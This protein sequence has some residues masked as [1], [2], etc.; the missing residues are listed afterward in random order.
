[1]DDLNERVY[2]LSARNP[3]RDDRIVLPHPSDITA[4]LLERTLA[5]HNILENLHEMVSNR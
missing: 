3:N 4:R 1:M 5:L 2:D